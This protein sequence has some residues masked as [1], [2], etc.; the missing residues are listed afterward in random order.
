MAGETTSAVSTPRRGASRKVTE[1]EPRKP[2]KKVRLD[3]FSRIPWSVLVV[4]MFVSGFIYSALFLGKE[5]IAFLDRPI[6]NVAISGDVA[7]VDSRALK[8][9]VLEFGQKGFLSSDMEQLRQE[10][11]RRGWIKTVVVKRFWP[12]GVELVLTEHTP[13]ARWGERAL[14]SAEGE[15]FEVVDTAPFSGLPVLDGSIGQEL[16]LMATYSDLNRQL[17][18]V[19]LSIE[20]LTQSSRGAWQL[21]CRNELKLNLGRD[22]LNEKM[23]KFVKVYRLALHKKIE[24]IEQVDLR[25]TNGLAV[26]WKPSEQDNNGTLRQKVDT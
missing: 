19:G 18:T 3:W 15:V 4:V 1:R 5:F 10:T 16:E 20:S 21:T 9:N 2:R 7:H 8:Q 23:N 17:S 6:V 13:V 11:E 12:Y 24:E 26:A 25:Y 22:R 14:L